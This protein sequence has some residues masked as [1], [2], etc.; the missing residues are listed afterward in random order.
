MIDARDMGM[1]AWFEANIMKVTRSTKPASTSS[2]DKSKDIKP[3]L[4]ETVVKD[5][6]N[7]VQDKPD[8]PDNDKPDKPDNDKDVNANDSAVESMETDTEMSDCSQENK[9]DIVNP[10][11]KLFDIVKD[12]G[13]VYHMVYEG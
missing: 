1:G 3:V 8:K 2:S 6:S 10:Y 11:D 4:S 12:D 5:S 9:N 13:F 7:T